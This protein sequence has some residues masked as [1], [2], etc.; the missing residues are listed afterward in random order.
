MFINFDHPNNLVSSWWRHQMETRFLLLALCEGNPLVTGGFPSQRPVTW[1]FG[2]FFDLH[3]NKWLSKQS[4][5]RWFETSLCSLWCH[6][7]D[8]S[9]V[10]VHQHSDND[11]PWIAPAHEIWGVIGEF[12]V[13]SLSVLSHSIMIQSG[14]IIGRS[15]F[16]EI[17]A[18]YIP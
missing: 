17:L 4:R 9:G 5:H 6:C 16:S 18:K 10:S 15:I 13:Y 8:Y 14:A 11:T 2:V 3:M 12:K 7:N 1:S